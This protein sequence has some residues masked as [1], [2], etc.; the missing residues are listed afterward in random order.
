MDER[1][2]QAVPLEVFISSSPEDEEQRQKLENHLSVLKHQQLITVWHRSNVSAGQRVAEE[3]SCHLNS[4][5]IILLLISPEFLASDLYH[6][7]LTPALQRHDAGTA[8]VL[9]IILRPVVWHGAPFQGLQILPDG[10]IPIQ[11]THW[12]STDEAWRHVADQLRIVVAE[13]KANAVRQLTLCFSSPSDTIEE[14]QL[15]RQVVEKLNQDVRIQSQAH[16]NLIVRDDQDIYNAILASPASPTH[17]IKPS[18]CDIVMVLFCSHMGTPLPGEIVKKDGTAYASTNEWDYEEAVNGARRNHDRPTVLVY[19]NCLPPIQAD[20]TNVRETYFQLLKLTHFFTQFTHTDS[21]LN[22]YRSYKMLDQFARYLEQDLRATL[23]RLSTQAPSVSPRRAAQETPVQTPT[24]GETDALLKSYLNWMIKQHSDLELRGLGGDARLPTIPLEQVY[25]ALKGIRATT[26]EREQ[27]QQ[28]LLDE[29]FEILADLNEDFSQTEPAELA[30]MIAYSRNQAV[31]ANPLLP[32]SIERDRSGQGTTATYENEVPITLGEAFRLKRWM[33]ILGDP[34]SGK[35]TLARWIALKLASALLEDEPAVMVRLHHVDPKIDKTDTT[36]IDIGPARLPVLLKVSEFADEYQKKRSAREPFSLVDFLG[37]H[38]WSNESPSLPQP[39]LNALIREYLANGRAILILD[40]MDEI[41][42]AYQRDDVIQAIEIFIDDWINARG[43]KVSVQGKH[44]LWDRLKREEPAKTGGNQIIITSREVGYG[45]RPIT[46]QVAHVKIQPMD[47]VAVEHFCDAWTLAIHQLLYPNEQSEI[48][49]RKATLEAGRL[50]KAIFDPLRPRVRELASNPLLI[51]I[52]ALVYRNNQGSLPQQRSELYQAAMKILIDT[53]RLTK[54]TTKEVE[55]I[56]SPLAAY[57]HQ[58]CPKDAIE[59]SDLKAIIKKSL[60]QFNNDDAALLPPSFG[61]KVADFIRCVREE[62]G[63][64]AERGKQIYGFL[65]LTFQ[66]Y[67]TALYLV[68]DQQHASQAIIEKL[69]DPRWHEPILMALGHVSGVSSD[70][71]SEDREQFLTSL[72]GADDPSGGRI[73]RSALLIVTAIPEMERVPEKVV[74]EIIRRLLAT[75]ADRDGIGQFAS[76]RERISGGLKI[77]YKS[78]YQHLLAQ[79]LEKAILNIEKGPRNLALAAAALL[80]ENEWSSEPLLKALLK[81][82]PYDDAEWEYPITRMLRLRQKQLPVA[83]NTLP[84]RKALEQEP[85]LVA[86]INGHLPWLRLIAL[87]YGGISENGC[88]THIV[89]YGEIAAVLQLKNELWQYHIDQLRKRPYWQSSWD[90]EDVV[91]NLAVHL[92]TEGGE[93]ARKAA[94][95]VP[96]FTPLAII[97]DSPLTALILQALRQKNPSSVLKHRLWQEWQTA[98]Q[99]IVRAYALL[100]LLLIDTAQAVQ[101]LAQSLKDATSAPAPLVLDLLKQRKYMLADVL[102]LLGE[103]AEIGQALAPLQESLTNEQWGDLVAIFF[104]TFTSVRSLP[105]KYDDVLLA[106]ATSIPRINAEIWAYWLSGLDGSGEASYN[107]AVILDTAGMRIEAASALTHLQFASNRKYATLTHWHIPSIPPK[108]ER[109][110]DLIGEALTVAHQSRSDVLGK[111]F[112]LGTIIYMSSDAREKNGINYREYP[113]LKEDALATALLVPFEFQ[114]ELIQLLDA[115]LAQLSAEEL[116]SHISKSVMAIKDPGIRSRALWRLAQSPYDWQSASFWNLAVRAAGQITDPLYRSCAFERLIVPLSQSEH[117]KNEALRAARAIKDPN[118]RARALARMALYENGARRWSLLSDALTSAK[119]IAR[120]PDQVETLQL[121]YPYLAENHQLHQTYDEIIKH[122]KSDWYRNKG[123]NVLSTTLLAFHERLH[124][125]LRLTP[126]IVASLID[127]MVGL[128]S[129]IGSDDLWSQLL[130]PVK[131]EQAISALL[132]T[133]SVQNLDGLFLTQH[134]FDVIRSLLD[135]HEICAIYHLLPYLRG[136]EPALLP[137][138]HLWLDNPPDKMVW[139]S[140]GLL[141]AESGE[142]NLKTIP[143]LLELMENGID[144]GRYRAGMV[145]HG[146]SVFV[147]KQNRDFRTSQLGEQALLL[148]ARA[149]KRFLSQKV[150]IGTPLGWV[151]GNIVH[152]DPLLFGQL[153]AYAQTEEESERGVSGLLRDI[154]YCNNDVLNEIIKQ[155]ETGSIKIQELL[156]NSLFLLLKYHFKPKITAVQHMLIEDAIAELPA[157]VLEKITVIPERLKTI[158]TL[159]CSVGKRI[160][161]KEVS[162]QA[163]LCTLDKEL[164]ALSLTLPESSIDEIIKHDLYDLRYDPRNELEAAQMVSENGTSL[165]LLFAWL[166]ACLQENIDDVSPFYHRTS[167]LLELAGAT[168]HFSPAAVYQLCAENNL[169]PVLVQAIMYHRSFYGREGA[170]TLLGYLRETPEAF[171]EALLSGLHDVAEVQTAIVQTMQNLRYLDEHM[172]SKMLHLL[173]DESASV[174]YTISKLLAS[175]TRNENI[176]LALRQEIVGA[177]NSATQRGY[178]SQPV[179]VLEKA[180][181]RIYIHNV[182][183]LDQQLYGALIDIRGIA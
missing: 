21:A 110:T 135:R 112:Y 99:D 18:E 58:N 5:Q 61:L 31:I 123:R 116:M 165:E 46:G 91:M 89:Q 136:F 4:A 139:L 90:Q 35:T 134:A 13:I 32:S 36:T 153:I 180:E 1:S 96:Q 177:I 159:L 14:R 15:V 107:Y 167:T 3:I 129:Q 44:L 93:L 95:Y 19:R 68:R 25:V 115:E 38:S 155:L 131:R 161:E 147:Q 111:L 54:I 181:A 140:V 59:E 121:L 81:A 164:H 138:L 133:I 48:L 64:L 62:V 57:I 100:A 162:F 98:S 166:A 52:L 92:D 20:T 43:Q 74:H 101:I 109:Y 42:N 37:Y 154:S 27:S 51:T 60:A 49:H 40:G 77:L 79:Y 122:L 151:W 6:T 45:I 127:E 179:F 143:C 120:E 105:V 158:A 104:R 39:G 73:P 87:L 126:V 10:A 128:H 50:K 17:T 118:N 157:D 12:F 76:L 117:I 108:Y 29:A 148:L 67:L 86:Y 8:R 85:E 106:N 141:L 113:G 183:R 69:D 53:W 70:W 28:L 83:H 171:D 23:A 130:H 124:E 137:F 11:S 169:G 102:T 160:D 26:Y 22:G 103:R 33:V 168:T 30:Q 175:I 55:Y 150:S 144:F 80:V 149:Q 182:G 152:D 88:A 82:F 163:A 142:V 97:N 114:Q 56:L 16:I 174:V 41:T 78:K 132:R 72:L 145:L 47:P 178:S 173:E 146:S 34:G 9:P 172:I 7:E 75:Y 125:P 176:T 24:T 94:A 2:E 63:L 170:A 156:L 84:L 119:K 71:G 66:E 65:H